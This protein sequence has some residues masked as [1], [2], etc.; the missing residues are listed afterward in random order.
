[1]FKKSLKYIK[2]ITYVVLFFGLSWAGL[3]YTSINSTTIAQTSEDSQISPNQIDQQANIIET[4][5]KSKEKLQSSRNEFIKEN[6]TL[7]SEITKARSEIKRLEGNLEKET[8]TQEEQDSIN[9]D[10][11]DLQNEITK[12]EIQIESNTKAI[13]E[14]NLEI[15]NTSEDLS[16]ETNQLMAL[17]INFSLRIFSYLLLIIVYWIAFRT[18]NLI[19]RRYLGN[20]TVS[21]I[22]RNVLLVV[23]MVATIITIL[24]AFVGNL[25]LLLGGTGLI[26]AALVVALQDFVSSFFAWI[27]ITSR[28]QYRIKDVIRL[29]VPSGETVFGEV[30]SIGLFRTTVKEKLGKDIVD[31]ERYTGRV[32]TFPNNLFLRVSVTN[33]THDNQILWHNFNLVITFE[34]NFVAAKEILKD[35]VQT[36]FQYYVDHRDQY[37]EDIYN[38]ENIYKPKIYMSISPSGPE[39]SIWFAAREGMLRQ[40]LQE[41]SESILEV[42]SM[43]NDINLAYDTYRIVTNSGASSLSISDINRPD[44]P[45]TRTSKV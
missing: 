23:A 28:K 20:R 32:I 5:K 2:I 37:L 21:T 42:F 24:F 15:Q 16:Q 3:N 7:N 26:S 29:Q 9:L 17:I 19:L 18:I 30:K 8:L 41:L 33:F 27:L 4:K 31:Q 12:K 39:F 45:I 6:T 34:S 10:I 13:D 14:L 43:H 35:I 25:E 22:A 36:K 44:Q 38:L 40:V 1:M 11:Q